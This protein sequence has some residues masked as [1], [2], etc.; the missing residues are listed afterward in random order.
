M[1]FCEISKKVIRALRDLF[2]AKIWLFKITNINTRK[3]CEIYSKLI[4]R[5]FKRTPLISTFYSSNI[6]TVFTP[7]FIAF[8]LLTSSMSIFWGGIKTFLRHRRVT[9]L[10]KKIET[11]SSS[12]QTGFM[13][14]L[15]RP[16]LLTL[17]YISWNH[18][19]T[20]WKFQGTKN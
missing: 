19:K 10:Q 11:T 16:A 4:I 15:E 20:N 12:N 7:F 8:F 1:S 2:P 5:T 3:R 14:V 17:A 18:Q 9:Q 6:N 13:R